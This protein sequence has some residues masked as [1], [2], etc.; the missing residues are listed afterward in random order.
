[1]EAGHDRALYEATAPNRHLHATTW[2][3]TG[4]PG[5]RCHAGPAVRDKVA[6]PGIAPEPAPAGPQH[7]D[8]EAGMDTERTPACV[9]VA[10]SRPGLTRAGHVDAL[11]GLDGMTY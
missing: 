8:E 3:A 9:T 1:V 5:G 4:R 10:G 2:P 6:R 7:V 11:E